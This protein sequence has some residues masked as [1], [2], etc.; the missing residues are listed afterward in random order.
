MKE[1]IDPSSLGV[2]SDLDP[3]MKALYRPIGL[4]VIRRSL[5]VC[6]TKEATHCSPQ[7]QSK[8]GASVMTTV[9]PKQEIYPCRRAL[10]QAAAEVQREEELRQREEQS[11]MVNKCVKTCEEET[12]PQGLCECERDEWQAATAVVLSL[13]SLA[14]DAL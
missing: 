6:D 7:R 13:G 12:A 10:A 9:N 3:L 4:R 5:K 1:P 11:T 14:G 2:Q 8:L